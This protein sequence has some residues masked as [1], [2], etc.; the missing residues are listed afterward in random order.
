MSVRGGASGDGDVSRVLSRTP[1][2][3]APVLR[4]AVILTG[5]ALLVTGCGGST[6][7]VE[8]GSAAST[9]SSGASGGS[10]RP[11]ESAPPA[12]STRA[13]YEL[14]ACPKV[15]RVAPVAGGLPPLTLPCLG[16]GPSVR[17]SDLRGTPMVL[18]VWAAW[19]TN[20]AREMPLFTAA[21]ATAGSRVRFFG[22]HFKAAEGYG[23]QSAADFGVAFPSVHDGDGDR[24]VTSL[25][26]TAPPTTLFVGAD[27]VVKGREIG[28]IKS[29]AQLDELVGR[30][31][32]VTL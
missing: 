15:P 28:E 17:L 31:L 10:S 9:A 26:V 18:N 12:G 21:V 7:S 11:D 20:C 29:Q 3:T 14:P 4:A 22:I 24:V 16:G 8:P 32:G 2:L 19:C 30:Y 13:A 1:V 25:R 6:G 5:F 23:L 27:G